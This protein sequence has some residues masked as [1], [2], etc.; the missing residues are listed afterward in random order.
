MGETVTTIKRL[1]FQLVD[2]GDAP[3]C[4]LAQRSGAIDTGYQSDA[5]RIRADTGRL[6]HDLVTS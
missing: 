1:G 5:Q 2:P 4:A 3:G 6:H